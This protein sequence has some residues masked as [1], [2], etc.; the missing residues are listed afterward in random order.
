MRTCLAHVEN[1]PFVK[2]FRGMK[3]TSA[4]DCVDCRRA[5]ECDLIYIKLI[6][7]LSEAMLPRASGRQTLPCKHPMMCA[8]VREPLREGNCGGQT[9]TRLN[10]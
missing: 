8:G 7:R 1:T 2:P 4:S 5:E 6:V 9:T 10:F 3:T